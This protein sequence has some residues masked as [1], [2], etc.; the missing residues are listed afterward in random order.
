M[1]ESIDDIARM[2]YARMRATGK[3][4]VEPIGDADLSE[5]SELIAEASRLRQENESLRA[6]AERWRWLVRHA[7]LCFD[8]APSWNAV[9][10]LPVFD[11][12]DQTITALVDT[13][14]KF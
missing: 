7:S 13:A 6:D 12:A 4:P 10:R 9:I 8:G 5:L 1:S 3:C 14:R 2:M 11:S